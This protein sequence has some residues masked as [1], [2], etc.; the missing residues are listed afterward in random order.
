MLPFISK[1]SRVDTQNNLYVK[2]LPSG[3]STDAME[4]VLVQNFGKYGRI[5]SST[6]KME[7]NL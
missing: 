1:Q 3:M 6:V 4:H 7:P 5:V 2:N